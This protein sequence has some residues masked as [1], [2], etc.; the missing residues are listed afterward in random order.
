MTAAKDCKEVSGTKDKVKQNVY[1]MKA[2]SK[3]S[4]SKSSKNF[5][6]DGRKILRCFR[7]DST[8]H[9]A[10]KC[11][12]KETECNQC[13]KKGH[14]QRCCKTSQFQRNS[15]QKKRK[16]KTHH[17]EA[18]EDGSSDDFSDI[19]ANLFNMEDTGNN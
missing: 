15:S 7:C 12:H 10:D 2:V 5:K 14:L 6:P 4:S 3:Q 16:N 8:E 19:L 11:V 18:N 9:L 17:I 13:K 1:R